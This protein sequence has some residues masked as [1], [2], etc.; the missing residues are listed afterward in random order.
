MTKLDLA[1]LRI[2]TP[3]LILRPIQMQDFEPW[4]RMMADAEAMRYLGGPVARSAAWRAFMT[5][6]GSWHLQGFSMFSLIEK[7]TGQW[8]GRVGPW[9]PADWPGT[10]VGWGVARSAWG[11]GYAPEAAAASIDWAFDVLGWTDVIHCIDV[12]NAN[13]AAVA[14]KL[15]SRNRGRVRMPAPYEKLEVDAWGQTRD[16]WRSRHQPLG[17]S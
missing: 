7:S 4:A 13:S 16:E 10:E 14:R 12:G 17:A 1:N 6:G 9:Q 11:K 3:R 8:V 2:E 15:G 5:M